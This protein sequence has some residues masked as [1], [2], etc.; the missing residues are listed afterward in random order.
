[1]RLWQQKYLV[2]RNFVLL[3]YMLCGTL[4]TEVV[5]VEAEAKL[6]ELIA[7]ITTRGEGI[8]EDPVRQILLLYTKDGQFVAER[9]NWRGC[10]LK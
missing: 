6:V 8:E 9:D 4:N 3:S 1:M 10:D 5:R 7:I 2:Y